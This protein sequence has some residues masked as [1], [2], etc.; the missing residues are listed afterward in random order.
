M[1]KPKKK[2]SKSKKQASKAGK[3]AAPSPDA[4]AQSAAG[5]APR[6]RTLVV[7]DDQ[8]QVTRH[9]SELA[10]ELG[11]AARAHGS[12]EEA[13][14]ALE[15]GEPADAVILDWNLGEGRMDGIQAL[16]EVHALR[17][18]M[19]VIMLTGEASYRL[20]VEAVKA[21]AT[22][23]VE[24]SKDLDE[25]LEMALARLEPVWGLVAEN[26]ALQAEVDR[27]QEAANYFQHELFKKYQIVGNSPA[28][29]AVVQ[30]IEDVAPIPR[31]VLVRGERGTG[32]ELVAAAIH[33][34]S[35]RSG[36]PFVTIN[37]AA[38]TE[39]LLECE[40]FGQEEG[41]YTDAR[42]RKGR[43]ELAHK[44]TLFLDEVGNMPLPFQQK[45]LRVLEYQEFSRVGG[46]ATIKVDVR[47]VAATNAD[48]E[49]RMADG[50]FRRDL[51]D[52]LTF[53][54]IRLP[55]L[56]ERKED[57]APLAL[58]FL[59]ILALEAPG[60]IPGEISAA[61]LERLES[62][63]WPG[64]VR[65]FKNYIERVAYRAKAQRIDEQHLLPFDDARSAFSAPGAT[66]EDKLR[67]VEGSLLRQALT[68]AGGD[69]SRA[70][71]ALGLS[72]ERLGELART[73]EQ[74]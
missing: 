23:F 2:T 50:A 63:D 16:A 62:H 60:A 48:L 74:D 13:V 9:V 11:F 44:G 67:F 38:F 56:R 73:H 39:G 17:P 43:F 42:F 30:V 29:Q 53:E 7:V 52:R 54:T 28:L 32:K 21:G 71:A 20:A 66:L 6:T 37:C 35:E 34:A 49:A 47:V 46:S 18:H 61:A 14:E 64:N 36:G 12:G 33:K 15:A 65:G 70:A 58:H 72:L 26:E 45:M 5:G 19:P 3:T 68:A 25:H 51:Y 40:M 24:K 41:G 55:P 8:P 59:S 69:H 10:E 4:S 57:L 31:P 22:D 27:L 1:A